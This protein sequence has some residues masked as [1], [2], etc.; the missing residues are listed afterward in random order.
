MVDDGTCGVDRV[1][2][3]RVDSTASTSVE[4]VMVPLMVEAMADSRAARVW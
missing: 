4:R 3:D 1:E 2:E